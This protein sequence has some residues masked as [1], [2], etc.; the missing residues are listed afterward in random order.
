MIS[1]IQE[2]QKS[3]SLGVPAEFPPEKW[4]TPKIEILQYLDLGLLLEAEILLKYVLSAP[5]YFYMIFFSFL[6][7]LQTRIIK[8]LI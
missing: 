3:G 5:Q 4:S 6:Y 7:I 8:F 2:G 1:V